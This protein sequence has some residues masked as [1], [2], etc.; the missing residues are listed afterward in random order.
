MT[1]ARLA[2]FILL[3]IVQIRA[4]SQA[5]FKIAVAM[6]YGYRSSTNKMGFLAQVNLY[7]R[8][9]LSVG[10]CD[11]KF[12]GGGLNSGLE[13]AFFNSKWHPVLGLAINRMWKNSFTTGDGNNPDLFSWYEVPRS[14]NIV[15]YLGL[16]WVSNDAERPGRK[17]AIMFY[18]SYRESLT[19]PDVILTRGVYRQNEINRINKSLA[20]GWGFGAR[21]SIRFLTSRKN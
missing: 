21:V 9:T 13:V 4:E 19:H 11:D 3:L 6:D 10:L 14:S 18:L 2:I 17:G 5:N 12:T 16:E 15:S 1:I 20:S 7:D 8:Y